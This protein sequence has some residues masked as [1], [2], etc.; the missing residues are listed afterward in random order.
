MLTTRFTAP[1]G[2]PP[3]AQTA[4]ATWVVYRFEPVA[5]RQT[6]VTVTMMGWGTGPAW[7]ASYDFFQRGNEWEMQQ[8]VRHF[9]PQPLEPAPPSSKGKT[10]AN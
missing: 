3:E 9:A 2:A 4:Q 10:P 1:E 6:R 8:L 5:P 7:D